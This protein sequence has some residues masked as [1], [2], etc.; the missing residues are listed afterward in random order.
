LLYRERRYR[1]V[2]VNRVVST[3]LSLVFAG[4]L[5]LWQPS[6]WV[7][8][9]QVISQL[10]F[11]A[12]GLVLVVRWRFRLTLHREHLKEVFGFSAYI[13]MNDLVVSFGTNAGVFILGRLVSAPQV[14]MFGLATYLTDTVRKSLMSILNRV[15]FVHYSS[16]QN[17]NA[18]LRQAYLTTLMWNCRAIFPVMVTIMLFGPSLLIHFLGQQWEPMGP[19]I[20]WLSLSVMIHAS[21]GT[22]ST[23]YKGIGRPRLDMLL[24]M[25]TTFL[26]LIPGM[27]AGALIAGL[28]GVAVAT[29]VTRLISIVIRQVLLDRI[30]GGTAGPVLRVVGYLLL[31]QAPIVIAWLVGLLWPHGWITDVALASAGLAIY[32]FIEIPRAFPQLAG[33]LGLGRSSAD[34]N[35]KR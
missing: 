20:R 34:R 8:I 19:V 31:L 5:L 16:I 17:D 26:I 33:R 14:G 32:G 23:L 15:T 1:V 29:A 27:I 24:F 21:G 9:G 18:K 3:L 13:L 2:A 25:A 12:I 28:T 10:I 7:V 6:A 30:I 22:N 35:V 11:S 4:A